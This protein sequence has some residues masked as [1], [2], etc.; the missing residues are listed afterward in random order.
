[1]PTPSCLPP[2][3][4]SQRVSPQRHGI[5]LPFAKPKEHVV[6]LGSDPP[7]LCRDRSKQKKLDGTS[8]MAFFISASHSTSPRHRQDA[9]KRKKDDETAEEQVW[10]VPGDDARPPREALPFE[11]EKEEKHPSE[12]TRE[13]PPTGVSLGT[14]VSLPP[15]SARHKKRAASSMVEER[16]T[17][18]G[19]SCMNR[20]SL[21][22]W[23]GRSPRRSEQTSSG[24]EKEKEEEE[25]EVEQEE[26]R[27]RTPSAATISTSM[28]H[29]P[30]CTLIPETVSTMS[31]VNTNKQSNNHN[32]NKHNN[33][34]GEE[35][36]D[37]RV[38]VEPKEFRGGSSR[39][40]GG[41]SLSSSPFEA[42]RNSKAESADASKRDPG[43]EESGRRRMEVHAH[44]PQEEEEVEEKKNSE[45]KREKRAEMRRITFTE[46]PSFQS[47]PPPSSPPFVGSSLVSFSCTT[48]KEKET[49][50]MASSLSSHCHSSSPPA[51]S[52][53]SARI[54]WLPFH[55]LLAPPPIPSGSSGG[56]SLLSG[57][58][59]VHASAPSCSTTH[60]VKSME[61]PLEHDRGV[62][63]GNSGPA[64][65]LSST[66][67]GVGEGMGGVPSSS[68]VAHV[69]SAGAA[70]CVLPPFVG[71]VREP[72]VACRAD[73]QE[74]RR[75]PSER[76]QTRGAAGEDHAE[77]NGDRGERCH[78]HEDGDSRCPSR[79]TA[80]HRKPPLPPEG[81]EEEMEAVA[82][83]RAPSSA[84]AF[85]ITLPPP[86]PP[87][88]PPLLL[89]SAAASSA[90]AVV[91]TTTS[92]MAILRHAGVLKRR[93][94][95]SHPPPPPSLFGRNS[96]HR[97]DTE[98]T[99][100]SSG[101]SRH[102]V[103][104]DRTLQSTG[105][106]SEPEEESEEERKRRE[107]GGS[108]RSSYAVCR[109][110][111][112]F[113]FLSSPPTSMRESSM[114]FF[115]EPTINTTPI[116]MTED[117][118]CSSPPRTTRMKPT[119]FPVRMADEEEPHKEASTEAETEGGSGGEEVKEE[120][121]IASWESIK[122]PYDPLSSSLPPTPLTATETPSLPQI[123]VS[124]PFSPDSV[125]VSPNPFLKEYTVLLLPSVSSSSSSASSS[126]SST[127]SS[128]C[129]SCASV[130]AMSSFSSSS[131]P[132]TP[133]AA[134]GGEEERGK[135]GGVENRNSPP[136]PPRRPLRHRRKKRKKR[137]PPVPPHAAPR[138][139]SPIISYESGREENPTA[140]PQR[141]ETTPE[142]WLPTSGRSRRKGLE[143]GHHTT[144]KKVQEVQ[145]NPEWRTR[146]HAP[147]REVVKE[148]TRGG[149]GGGGG[150]STAWASS[151]PAGSP[152]WHFSR[153]TSSTTEFTSSTPNDASPTIRS[154]ATL[155]S[156]PRHRN[157]DDTVVETEK[158]IALGKR[159]AE[160]V[161][162]DTVGT[163]KEK[164]TQKEHEDERK[165]EIGGEP[166]PTA[167]PDPP[168]PSS[169]LV[170][171]LRGR[172]RVPLAF[173]LPFSPSKPVPC[174]RNMEPTTQ[175][176]SSLEDLVRVSMKETQEKKR[177]A[178]TNEMAESGKT[179]EENNTA[180][181]LEHE[182]L[183]LGVVTTTTGL[184]E[185]VHESPLTEPLVPEKKRR[186]SGFHE[187]SPP[188][189]TGPLSDGS[190][191]RLSSSPPIPD[192]IPVAP[193]SSLDG[194]SSLFCHASLSSSSS[195]FSTSSFSSLH[196]S[197]TS[198]AS[199][200]ST[201]CSSY[202][203]SGVSR[204]ASEGGEG[205]CSASSWPS[206]SEP[207]HASTLTC[208]FS[209][210]HGSSLSSSS[211]SGH[212]APPSPEMVIAVLATASLRGGSP[213]GKPQPEVPKE[214]KN[215]LP[216]NASALWI[217]VR[218]RQRRRREQNGEEPEG[219]PGIEQGP[220]PPPHWG[221]PLP[222]YAA[223]HRRRH[224]PRQ[225]HPF[226]SYDHTSST[227]KRSDNGKGEQSLTEQKGRRK[228][229]SDL[230][231]C[232]SEDAPPEET[233]K[234]RR[235]R[236]R[237]EEKRGGSVTVLSTPLIRSWSGLVEP[238]APL[239]H[240]DSERIQDP[241]P[242]LSQ[243]YPPS[244]TKRTSSTP[245]SPLQRPTTSSRHS[246][247][248]HHSLMVKPR[249]TQR[250]R[251]SSSFLSLPSYSSLSSMRSGSSSHA[252]LPPPPTGSQSGYG[253]KWS[254]LYPSHTLTPEG[255]KEEEEE[256]E[257]EERPR[258]SNPPG[259]TRSH[260]GNTSASEDSFAPVGGMVTSVYQEEN[261]T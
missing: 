239:T 16:H 258:S 6:A 66:G 252:A 193:L 257:E 37:S 74:K 231:P 159:P 35:D 154:S 130:H 233:H 38:G 131:H 49:T 168:P 87:P 18:G 70:L 15:Y 65:W 246:R 129:R 26:E 64:G 102:P 73:P 181:D 125:G 203:F 52:S 110:S 229:R 234:K 235:R 188:S 173:S 23:S 201:S 191:P 189:I 197:R 46:P 127:G 218:R 77:R 103:Q 95:S 27:R 192:S 29:N 59:G 7:S 184:D 12:R 118:L 82:S 248:T 81:E 195:Y 260:W 139:A 162:D 39:P 9:K 84:S 86:P 76:K 85:C 89:S 204:P 10:L 202:S 148:Q 128:S 134:A 19:T 17:W 176:E 31:S 215:V 68:C 136:L 57:G 48:V 205:A 214:R 107:S 63:L 61:G 72:V 88:P 138:Q 223:S 212:G 116:L 21:S 123:S 106:S 190:P 145:R 25:G 167:P 141:E 157:E 67:E 221:H 40:L 90:A 69:P 99:S 11:E 80:A 153:C 251:R 249:R 187:T 115:S 254:L 222:C 245:P 183:P 196:P 210:A 194:I 164:D 50:D 137:K 1:M 242:T 79:S 225:R 104:R 240:T 41:S 169:S 175:E 220:P 140:M 105:T 112:S 186:A 216:T 230:M 60:V 36:E 206:S 163:E 247:K 209:S 219:D 42:V 172:R 232:T 132:E 14:C 208:P 114:H 43:M 237:K 147:D 120:K 228:G 244:M 54:S 178:P 97:T 5:L 149:G 180:H 124:S 207:C 259:S 165:E 144:E 146:R 255:R 143:K 113:S 185:E 108:P 133:A 45:T 78:L 119:K 213:E 166:L 227:S 261:N 34:R 238:S 30:T 226:A 156:V 13:A 224:P 151:T 56:S 24:K 22:G 182:D 3:Q 161:D 53:P 241:S 101:S 47:P 109:I 83:S 199:T 250:Y 152:V 44:V 94:T 55:S 75:R 32:A 121:P 91:G 236:R 198:L 92:S 111:S 142:A 51:S 126:S 171:G 122:L 256:G 150:T 96:H 200:S 160:A 28:R 174:T 217:Q 155:G 98:A 93:Q 100:A 177:E 135:G 62:L 4:R 158:G 71:G 20:S 117:R 179:E 211:Y 253:S 170:R 2:L 8:S 33:L 243:L 58:H